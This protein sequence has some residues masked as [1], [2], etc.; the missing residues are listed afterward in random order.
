M[1]AIVKKFKWFWAWQDDKEEEWLGE[2]AKQGLHLQRPA[3]FGRYF[4]VQGAPLEY[5]YRLDFVTSV[6]KKEDYYQLFQDA[7]W[8]HVSE[9]GGWQYWRKPI[10]DGASLEIFTDTDSKIQKYRR[11]LGFMAFLMPIFV[12]NVINHG[13]IYMRHRGDFINGLMDGMY[14]TLYVVFLILAVS[15]LMIVRRI[16]T[17]KRR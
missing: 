12:V 11:L 1:D 6:K 14:Y 13:N 2:M 15:A 7:G 4:F 3:A 17:L 10:Q 16:A 8:E 9:M 5:A